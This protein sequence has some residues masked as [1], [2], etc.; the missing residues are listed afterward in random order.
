MTAKQ[1]EIYNFYLK[2]YRTNNNKPFKPKKDF[3]KFESKPEYLDILKLDK[4]FDK[5]P[6][7]LNMAF[8]DAPYKIYTDEKKFYNLKFYAS[9]KGFTTCIA[10][11]KLLQNKDPD[12]QIDSIKESLIFIKRFCEDNK[13]TLDRYFKY[14]SVAQYDFLKHIKEHKINWYVAVGMQRGIELLYGLPKDE[15]ILYY[16]PDVS[17]SEIRSKLL[18]SKSAKNLIS[19]GEK[20]I[21][22]HLKS[23]TK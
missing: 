7:L 12:E 14:A 16:G 1:Q 18:S 13:L 3:S 6:H 23:F 10:Y 8:F 19:E 15:F 17:L 2:A 4:F 9:V 22:N 20:R 5:H 11:Y 21:E